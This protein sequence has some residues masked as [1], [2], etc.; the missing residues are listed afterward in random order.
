LV[1]AWPDAELGI[2]SAR[3]AVG[4]VHRREL[5][6]AEDVDALRAQLADEYAA[7]HLGAETA[8]ASGFVDELVEPGDTRRRLAAALWTLAGSSRS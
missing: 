5:R 3:A 8:A 7:E 4:V 2:M 1:L 6:A